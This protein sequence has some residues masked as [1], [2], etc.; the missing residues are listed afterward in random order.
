MRRSLKSVPFYGIV[1]AH[2]NASDT[3]T[4]THKASLNTYIHNHKRKH[5]QFS[6][7]RRLSCIQDITKLV[8]KFNNRTHKRVC[9]EI[10]ERTFQHFG[11]QQ[12]SDVAQSRAIERPDTGEC[13][14]RHERATSRRV[15]TSTRHS[16]SRLT[17]KAHAIL[18]IYAHDR[19]KSI[20]PTYETDDLHYEGGKKR[21]GT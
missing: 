13:R 12:T 8:Q 14:T 3:H 4:H 5:K 10:A 11:N 19:L 6:L 21:G 20:F 7:T 16:F 15:T 1:R 2:R 9:C 18:V 17:F